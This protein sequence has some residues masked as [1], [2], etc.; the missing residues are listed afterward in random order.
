MGKIAEQEKRIA[1][2]KITI[3]CRNEH[4]ANQGY[5]IQHQK[6][7]IAQQANLISKQ[8]VQIQQQELNLNKQEA[9][10]QQQKLNLN[11]QKEKIFKQIEIIKSKNISNKRLINMLDLY[12]NKPEIVSYDYA[13]I[14]ARN[15]LLNKEFKRIN[16]L[17]KLYTP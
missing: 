1:K 14:K 13:A 11:K 10:I 16:K 9:Q 17:L 6:M 7:Q 8:E 3:Q 15:H 4:L 12:K 2:Q 5:K